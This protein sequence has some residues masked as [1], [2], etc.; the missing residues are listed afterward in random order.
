[1]RFRFGTHDADPTR[2]LVVDGTAEGFRS[3]SHWPGNA[4]P[5]VLKHD[6]STGIA[7]RFVALTEE[8]RLA[9]MGRF[10]EVANTHYDTDGVASV[11][12]VMRPEEALPR[13]EALLAAAATGDF[14]TWN[15]R[16]AL[17]VE[18]TLAALPT[19][20]RSPVAVGLP[21]A[22]TDEQRWEASYRWSID[23][24]PQVLDDP[25][26]WEHLWPQ[27]HRAVCADVAAVDSGQAVSVECF[28]A[29]DL[30][31]ITVDRP[32]AAIALH[33]AAGA[34]YRL[35]VVEPAEGGHHYR[36]CYRDESWF[37]LVSRRPAPRVTLDDAVAA[38][39]RLELAAGSRDD[40]R[41]WADPIDGPVPQLGYGDTQA[42]RPGF[43]LDPLPRPAPASRLEPARVLAVLADTLSRSPRP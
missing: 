18:L 32:L 20:P 8:R 39:Q 7:L 27:R 2:T 31:V 24:L 3:L 21:A 36:F 43:F 42:P 10:D 13:A 17:A 35:L 40:A 4:T 1:M 22:A 5:S 15:G 26:R 28:P 25:F 12:T 30:A 29:L 14:A 19:H 34:L 6:L 37:E 16:E 38:L 33:H 9:L 11:F 41:W 23:A